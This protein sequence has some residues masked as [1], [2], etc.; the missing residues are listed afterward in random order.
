MFL[1]EY[2][3]FLDLVSN[4]PNLLRLFTINELNVNIRRDTNGDI[5][6]LIDTFSVDVFPP[7]A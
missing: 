1:R 4:H 2:V 3:H 5:Y 7:S 6:L